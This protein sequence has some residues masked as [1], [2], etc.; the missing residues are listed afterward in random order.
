MGRIR[1]KAQFVKGIGG[2]LSDEN[3]RDARTVA[4]A[5]VKFFKIADVCPPLANKDD[6]T[7]NAQCAWDTAKCAKKVISGDKCP[8]YNNRAA[9]CAKDNTC[10]YKEGVCAIKTGC[11]A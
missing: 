7:N 10:F 11:D 9:D 8:N 4:D 5:N 3:S 2:K 6:C 1:L